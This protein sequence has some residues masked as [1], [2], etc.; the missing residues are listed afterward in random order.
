MSQC[1]SG[2]IYLENRLKFMKNGFITNKKDGKMYCH[3]KMAKN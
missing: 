1:S 2:L 3:N